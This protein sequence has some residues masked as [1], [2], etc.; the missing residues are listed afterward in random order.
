MQHV[1]V[2]STHFVVEERTDL[3]VH[4]GAVAAEQIVD[5][6]DDHAAFAFVEALAHVEQAGQGLCGCLQLVAQA[7]Q[8]QLAVFE[9][10]IKLGDG[11]FVLL[12]HLHH[13]EA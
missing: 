4:F 8:G 1:K 5:H 10:V 7:V 3:L 6:V 13:V 12:E 2:N 9:H 11:L